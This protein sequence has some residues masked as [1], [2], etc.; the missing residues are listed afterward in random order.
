ME[1]NH[2]AEDTIGLNQAE[3]ADDQT[4]ERIM[5]RRLNPSTIST[6]NNKVLQLA[7]RLM[8]LDNAN[9]VTEGNVYLLR[10]CQY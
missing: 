4:G 7:K 5:S 8:E 6:Y 9:Y 2:A 1:M 10:C 3:D